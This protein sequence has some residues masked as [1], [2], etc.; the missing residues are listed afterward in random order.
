[1]GAD[2]D[3]QSMGFLSHSP[4]CGCYRFLWIKCHLSTITIYN[5]M[6]FPGGT[7]HPGGSFAWDDE[8]GR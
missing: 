4:S 5:G 1:M 8:T 3:Q 7:T 6:H 2:S